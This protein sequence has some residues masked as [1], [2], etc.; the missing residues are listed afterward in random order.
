MKCNIKQ[1]VGNARKPKFFNIT[2][3]SHFSWLVAKNL[4]QDN[5]KI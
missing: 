5:K 4:G 1:K 2:K 3:K